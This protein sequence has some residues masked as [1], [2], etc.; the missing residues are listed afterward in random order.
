M[1]T[2]K[3]KEPF[4]QVELYAWVGEDELGSGVVGIKQGLVPA[5]CIPLVA[6]QREKMDRLKPQMEVQAYMYGKR[7]RLC[8]FQFIE[9]VSETNAG[10]EPQ[11]V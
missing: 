2:Q 1:S 10:E 11:K 5:G 7:I 3:R 9:V 4:E 6:I 8:R